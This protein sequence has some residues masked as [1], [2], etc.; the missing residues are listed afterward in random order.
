MSD[1]APMIS[2]Q[3]LWKIFGA[4]AEKVIGSPLADLTRSEL[5]AQTGNTVAVRDVSFNV[6]AGEVFV[7]MG[8]SG[9]GK[10]TLV[11]CMTRLIEPTAGSLTF[12]GEDVLTVDA[13][14]L[15]ATYNLRTPDAIHVATALVGKADGIVTNDRRW[16][17]LSR[18][19]LKI[20]MIDELT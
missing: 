19:G 18:E 4:N 20:W 3:N 11:R 15:R 16:R 2:V 10:S 12:E 13:A 1:S 14:R 17:R 8:L 7:V 5:R 6:A 9:S